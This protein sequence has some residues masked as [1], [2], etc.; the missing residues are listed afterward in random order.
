MY[1]FGGLGLLLIFHF[2]NSYN[3]YVNVIVGSF[4]VIL[5]EYVG[6]AFCE[7]VLKEKLWDYSLSKAQLNGHIDLAHSVAWIFLVT[8]SYAYVYPKFL[9][10]NKLVQQTINISTLMDFTIFILFTTTFIVLTA[11]TK[12]WRL[13]ACK[14][15]LKA[16]KSKTIRS[17]Q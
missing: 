16:L 8:I 9:E 6:G 4:A 15:A 7:V 11:Y 2:L 14:V 17:K 3:A 10:I 12:K 1:G 5:I 13:A